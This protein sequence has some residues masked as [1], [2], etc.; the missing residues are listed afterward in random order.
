M[1]ETL[2]ISRLSLSKSREPVRM[3]DLLLRE[4]PLVERDTES[5]EELVGSRKVTRQ[6]QHR[7]TTPVIG[8]DRLE[9][10][11]KNCS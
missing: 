6:S 4:S 11:R 10:S 1:I 3:V 9:R 7:R 8:D 2:L 5:L